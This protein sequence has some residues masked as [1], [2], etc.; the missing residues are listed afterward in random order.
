MPE[1]RYK[2]R[3]ARCEVRQARLF[4][5]EISVQIDALGAVSCALGVANCFDGF[6]GLL[7]IGAVYVAVGDEAHELAI[8][9]T[10]E[11]VVVAEFLCEILGGHASAAY[12]EDEDVGLHARH[13]YLNARN[14]G[15]TVCEEP[16]IGVIFM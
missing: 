9:C 7:A 5:F 14:S 11:D 8:D 6:Q 2:V 12:V 16:G 10:G 1:D 13:V 15:E 3:G 4:G